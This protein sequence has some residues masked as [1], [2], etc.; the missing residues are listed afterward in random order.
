MK[1]IL[2]NR[3]HIREYL[4]HGLWSAIAFAIPVWIFFFFSD[5]NQIWIFYIGTALFMFTHLFYVYKLSLRR[6]EYKSSW[7]M[8]I[9]AH[10]AV[11]TGIVFAVILTTILCF[12]YIPG[13]L[14]GD[15]ENI[16]R[17]APTGLNNQNWNLLAI[18][19]ICATV[20]NFGSA[21]FMS[22]LGPYVFKKNQM[23]DKTAVLDPEI[24]SGKTS[25]A[26]PRRS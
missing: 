17:D 1:N 16:L 6:P 21:G 12:I 3:Q 26:G 23:K 11:L 22:V 15:S 7:M 5:Y 2:Y 18:L 10:L 8:I 9:A 25:T 20:A 13:F 14:S 24:K 19:Y 4:R